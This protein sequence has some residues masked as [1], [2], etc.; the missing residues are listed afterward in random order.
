MASVKFPNHPIL[1]NDYPTWW[2]RHSNY[3]PIIPANHHITSIYVVIFKKGYDVVYLKQQSK[4][5]TNF[6]ASPYTI[7]RNDIALLSMMS[8]YNLSDV[9]TWHHYYITLTLFLQGHHQMTSRNTIGMTLPIWRHDV[10]SSRDVASELTEE[11]PLRM[12]LASMH[13]GRSSASGV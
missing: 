4:F 5:N 10:T 9:I 8:F 7:Y 12:T 11:K 2:L 1:I 6:Q 3:W 13:R